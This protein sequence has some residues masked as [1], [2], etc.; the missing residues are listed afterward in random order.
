MLSHRNSHKSQLA[1]IDG[2]VI[3]STV[4]AIDVIW[5]CEPR[6]L[7]LKPLQDERQCGLCEARRCSEFEERAP[8]AGQEL[9]RLQGP[10]DQDGGPRGLGRVMVS[11]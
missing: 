5:V 11:S 7:H 3:L 9:G 6:E 4:P 8:A 2:G 1:R 10:W